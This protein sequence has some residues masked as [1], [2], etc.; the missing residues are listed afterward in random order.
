[1]KQFDMRLI[2]L[3]SALLLTATLIVKSEI[4]SAQTN[5]PPGSWNR[6]VIPPR[7]LPVD[8][9]FIDSI[10]GVG[11][12]GS[13]I[14]TMDG[15]KSWNIADSVPVFS[16]GFVEPFLH[17]VSCT[18]QSKAIVAKSNCD[19]LELD[20][21]SIYQADCPEDSPDSSFQTY[22]PLDQKMYD[23]SYGFRFVQMSQRGS[24]LD[25]AY[26]SVT[27][28]GW[29]TYASFGDSLIGT[30]LSTQSGGG[31]SEIGG[32]T[33]VDSNEVWVDVHN[34]IYRTT[35]AGTTW[36]T[37]LPLVGTP[38]SNSQANIYDF[39]V[40]RATQE[41]YAYVGSNPIDYLYS[42]DYGKTWQIDSV[43]KGHIASIY[44][45]APHVLWA[46]I[47][48]DGSGS[49]PIRWVGYSSDNGT[50][51]LVDSTTFKS[52]DSIIDKMYWLDDR[53]AWIVANNSIPAPYTDSDNANSIWYYHADEN[54]NVQTSIV[55]IK[56]GTIQVYPD[57]ATNVLYL[58]EMDD[59]LEIY[60]PL[61]RK[62]SATANGNSLDI[63]R[64][65]SGVYFLYD[66]VAVRAKFVKE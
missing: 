7:M 22:T 50:T 16:N 52:E 45:V 23:T 63:S 24:I 6:V 37:I 17:A 66:G 55:G 33:I 60:D 21:D 31:E 27:H 15:G 26:I 2:W 28:D 38:Y 40:N 64:L 48:E 43:F 13:F 42:S 62:Y 61:G 54:A 5:N 25:V 32:A 47:H 59:A 53:H 3:Q 9:G 65:P 12:G 10:N 36:D 30:E 56:Y 41:V 51:W 20:G 57:P 4:A 8:I 18:G 58:N 19:Q 39:I 1:M 34:T 35:N 46:T 49:T 14:T 29:R 44:M 11:F